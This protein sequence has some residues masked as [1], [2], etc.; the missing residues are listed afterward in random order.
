[1]CCLLIIKTFLLLTLKSFGSVSLLVFWLLCVFPQEVWRM[2]P[3]WLA[4]NITGLLNRS[5][6]PDLDTEL[7]RPGWL[8]WSSPLHPHCVGAGVRCWSQPL[9]RRGFLWKPSILWYPD[10]VACVL[11]T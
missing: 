8:G 5:E 11:L 4:I 1:M 7:P 2:F 3:Y 9:C 6:A 10:G